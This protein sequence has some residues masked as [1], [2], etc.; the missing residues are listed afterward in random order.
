MTIMENEYAGNYTGSTI[1]FT[2]ELLQIA[3][4]NITV[5]SKK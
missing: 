3:I 4:Y 5:N 2:G 1:G